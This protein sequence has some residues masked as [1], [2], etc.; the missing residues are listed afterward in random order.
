MITIERYIEEHNSGLLTEKEL[1]LGLVRHM[2]ASNWFEVV[3]SL[4]DGKL[5]RF[6]QWAAKVIEGRICFVAGAGQLLSEEEINQLERKL[7]E[8]ADRGKDR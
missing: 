4:P 5:G 7:R 8:L 6:K 3:K 2:D 1:F